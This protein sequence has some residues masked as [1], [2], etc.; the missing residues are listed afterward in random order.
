MSFWIQI[1]QK[2]EPT[3]FSFFYY[4]ICSSRGDS[5]GKIELNSQER[6]NFIYFK[7][8]F[9]WTKYA[10]RIF[11][12]LYLIQFQFCSSKKVNLFQSRF[13]KW[14]Q[15]FPVISPWIFVFCFH[16]VNLCVINLVSPSFFR[17]IFL[18][19]II[20]CKQISVSRNFF[21]KCFKFCK[22]TKYEYYFTRSLFKSDPF[23]L[24]SINN[25]IF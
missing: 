1:R 18:H 11:H 21:F 8:N 10:P 3:L 17:I 2:Y 19:K 24:W 16:K 9:F 7:N 14:I 23:L 15:F 4:D 5:T 20:V 13:K 6:L 22:F 25:F 12:Y